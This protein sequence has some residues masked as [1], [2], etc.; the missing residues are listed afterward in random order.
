MESNC[1]LHYFQ[2]SSACDAELCFLVL[3]SDDEEELHVDVIGTYCL[4]THI[5][6]PVSISTCSI[7]IFLSSQ[8]EIICINCLQFV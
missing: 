2:L 7:K 4:P 1:V 8:I 5:K 6:I 3:I